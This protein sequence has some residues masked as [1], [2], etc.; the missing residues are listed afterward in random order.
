M[1][2]QNVGYLKLGISNWQ[3]VLTLTISCF[4]LISSFHF[5]VSKF[6]KGKI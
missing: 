4:L 2:K 1:H 6:S 3:L 5:L